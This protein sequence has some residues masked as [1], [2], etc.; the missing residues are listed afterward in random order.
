MKLKL[1]E[2]SFLLTFIVFFLI[3]NICLVMWY[4][5]DIKSDYQKF[6]DSCMNEAEN[7]LYLENQIDSGAIG[8]DEMDEIAESYEQKDVYIRLSF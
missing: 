2:K 5:L 7:I 4:M 6:A 8:Q 1:W 3:L